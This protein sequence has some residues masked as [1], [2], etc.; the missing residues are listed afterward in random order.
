MVSEYDVRCHR[1][2][3]ERQA[4]ILKDLAEGLRSLPLKITLVLNVFIPIILAHTI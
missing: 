2:G 1:V 3:G 4:R